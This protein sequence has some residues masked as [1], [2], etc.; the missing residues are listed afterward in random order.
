[1]TARAS[2]PTRRAE[3]VTAPVRSSCR[4]ALQ[5]RCRSR[6]NLDKARPFMA[7]QRAVRARRGGASG[8]RSSRAGPDFCLSDSRTPRA[9]RGPMA[10]R[11][12]GICD[13]QHK[14]AAMLDGR[15]DLARK[16]PR[17]RKLPLRLTP[18]A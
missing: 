6:L 11:S 17:L 5:P 15:I 14:A 18:Q 3:R 2:M 16:P 4:L 13:P 10:Y 8:E 1:V 7:H 9:A 12:P